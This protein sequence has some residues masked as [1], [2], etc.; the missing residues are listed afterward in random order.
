MNQKYMTSTAISLQRFLSDE[1][2]QRV[3]KMTIEAFNKLSL[4]KQ[5]KAKK[6]VGIF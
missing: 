2:F 1:E 6:S 4:W 5:G 3:F